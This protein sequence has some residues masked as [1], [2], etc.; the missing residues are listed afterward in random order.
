MLSLADEWWYHDLSTSSGSIYLSHPQQI[1][2][3]KPWYSSQSTV[4]QPTMQ[5]QA[6]FWHASNVNHGH[7][8]TRSYL[9]KWG[10]GWCSILAV[11]VSGKGFDFINPFEDQFTSALMQCTTALDRSHHK[12]WC[13][14]CCYII[15]IS[16]IKHNNHNL[17]ESEIHLE[18]TTFFAS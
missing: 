18:W 16:L 13:H 10:M 8:H 11:T 17:V 3:M 7:A 1:S 9:G 4:R 5:M 15:Y 12:V 2:C 14:S 6:T